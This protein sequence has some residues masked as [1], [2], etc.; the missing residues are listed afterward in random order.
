M[1]LTANRPAQVM[2]ACLAWL[3]AALVPLVGYW[4]SPVAFAPL[5]D[6]FPWL[7]QWLAWPPALVAG[8]CVIVTVANLWNF[9]HERR[10]PLRRTSKP[11]EPSRPIVLAVPE[12]KAEDAEIGF[13]V[14]S[15]IHDAAANWRRLVANEELKRALKI[16]AAERQ[17]LYNAAF[18][19]K[20]EGPEDLRL[21]LD[22][23]RKAR[24]RQAGRT[25]GG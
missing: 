7:R 16:T 11:Y 25:V 12:V 6:A 23:I 17:A 21:M 13:S 4:Y 18:M 24:S 8:F 2:Q 1:L 3:V 10:S 14:S 22:A 20:A 9:W 5:T 15:R 19:G